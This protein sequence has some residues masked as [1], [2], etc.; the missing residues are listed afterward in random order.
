MPS[1]PTGAG[2]EHL[3]GLTKLRVLDLRGT[4]VTDTG[5]TALKQAFPKVNIFD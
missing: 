1:Q 3:T 4:Q 2:P 5:C